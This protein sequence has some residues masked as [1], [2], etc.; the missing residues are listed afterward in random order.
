[1]ARRLSLA[2]LGLVAASSVAT[3]SPFVPTA[4]VAVSGVVRA[5]AVPVF[6]FTHLFN[7]LT[8]PLGTVPVR[9]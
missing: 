4:A 6:D 5:T 7:R 8:V 9:D 2:L 1:M 3:A